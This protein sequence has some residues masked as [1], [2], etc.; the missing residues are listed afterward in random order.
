V[1]SGHLLESWFS[2]YSAASGGLE[3]LP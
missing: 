2:A 3:E 1:W